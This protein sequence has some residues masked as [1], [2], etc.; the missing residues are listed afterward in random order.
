MD[1][2]FRKRCARPASVDGLPYQ[3]VRYGV[4]AAEMGGLPWRDVETVRRDRHGRVT[5]VEH[6]WATR[7]HYFNKRIYTDEETIS[8]QAGRYARGLGSLN[9][10]RG[11]IGTEETQAGEG[12]SGSGDQGAKQD[13]G[14]TT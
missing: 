3:V 1:F 8:L 4:S 11:P 5:A 2:D 13:T 9:G 12:C 7:R 10:A 6:E 14:V